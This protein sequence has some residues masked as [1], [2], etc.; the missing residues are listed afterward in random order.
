MRHH[1]PTSIATVDL[2]T[3]RQNVELMKSVLNGRKLLAVVKADAYGHG[4]STCAR[5]LNSHVDW[6]AVATIDEGIEL[7]LSG[8]EK[9]ILILGVPDERSAPAYVSHQ[10]TATISHP[11][12]FSILMDGTRYQLNIDTGMRRLG[13]QPDQF[14]EVRTLAIMNQRLIANGIYSHLA[15][16]DAVESTFVKI[17]ESRFKEALSIFPEIPLRHLMNSAGLFYHELDH[18]DMV[19]VGLALWGYLS[20][21][22]VHGRQVLPHMKPVYDH[23]GKVLTW[24]SQIVQSRR[25]EKGEGVSYGS[26]WKAPD[27]GYISTIPVGYADGLF[28]SA[29]N[30]MSVRV[31][32][33]E[34]EKSVFPIAGTV[35]MD[36]IMIF[37]GKLKLRPG[38]NVDL[39]SDKGPDAWDWAKA[40][41]TI[42]YEVLT[43][44]SQRV[45]REYV[46][47]EGLAD[48]PSHPAATSIR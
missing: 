38:V 44:I 14:E 32:L 28:R 12:H 29:T 36:Y 42:P 25:I 15:T 31:H 37:T 4:A 30:K 34:Q 11:S 8:V 16:A 1:F 41:D 22:P 6:F 24:S 39:L 18:F 10:L 45:V 17:Q 3:L 21:E 7:R 43:K 46:R 26:R 33:S 19:R 27:D 48:A 47:D 40:A 2:R 9:P 13:I 35:T 23:L 5:Y 20:A